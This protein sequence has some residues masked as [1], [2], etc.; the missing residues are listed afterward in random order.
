MIECFFWFHPLVSSPW[1]ILSAEGGN[2]G[3][4][5]GDTKTRAGEDLVTLGQVDY[6][7]QMGKFEISREM[8]DDANAEGGLR[9]GL[10]S[11]ERQGGRLPDMPQRE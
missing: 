9:I 5:D 2:P 1:P 11:I 4:P 6:V 3:N 7:Y 10:N 8:V